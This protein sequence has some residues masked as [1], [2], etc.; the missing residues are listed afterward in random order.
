MEPAKV[1]PDLDIA[2]GE[3]FR[4]P[5]RRIAS[6][7]R[8][9]YAGRMRSRLR[10]RDKA[11]RGAILLAAVLLPAAAVLPTAGCVAPQAT[12]PQGLGRGSPGGLRDG[13]YYGEGSSGLIR[14]VVRVT[15]LRGEVA[16]IDVLDTTGWRGGEAESLIPRRILDAQSTDVD[17]VTG[18]TATSW[19]IMKS[20]QRALD[21][22]AQR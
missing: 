16:T 4:A 19:A 8:A 22:A 3:Q 1:W 14:S 13:V 6:I 10:P 2:G 21:E 11:S 5:A 20:V 15:I 18:A 9:G 7:R 17:A 12:A